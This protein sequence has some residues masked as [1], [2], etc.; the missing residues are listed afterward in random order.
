MSVDTKS[1]EKLRRALRAFATGKT[2]NSEFDAELPLESSD[3]GVRAI[4]VAAWHMYSD[5]D[6]YRARGRHSLTR[7]ERRLV[8]RSLLFLESGL[9]YGWTELGPLASIAL[10]LGNLLSLGA[11]G[12]IVRRQHGQRD[13]DDA[14]PFR[15]ASELDS[16]ARRWLRESNRCDGPTSRSPATP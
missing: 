14:W 2:T 9:D 10:A 12:S 3:P 15:D 6:D 16:A 4:C 11:V 7:S 13:P 5:F 1:R 8:A